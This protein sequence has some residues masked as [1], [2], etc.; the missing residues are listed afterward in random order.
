MDIQLKSLKNWMISLLFFAITV[1]AQPK[2]RYTA[3]HEHF[4]GKTEGSYI[5]LA[6]GGVGLLIIIAL[7]V[8]LGIKS[9]K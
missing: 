8:V 3:A 1:S 7:F 5:Y 9:K 2:S 6:I 4:A